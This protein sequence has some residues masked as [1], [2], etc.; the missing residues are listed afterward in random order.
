M[1]VTLFGVAEGAV[2]VA[3]GRMVADGELLVADR[4][5]RLS[6]RLVARQRRQDEACSPRTKMPSTVT[7]PASATAKLPR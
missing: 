3:L 5:Y 7:F 4:T 2:R 1:V 6:E